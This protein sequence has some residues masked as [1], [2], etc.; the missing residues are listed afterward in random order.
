MAAAVQTLLRFFIAFALLLA[1]VLSQGALALSVDPA[2]HQLDR[3]EQAAPAAH[4]SA[5][6]QAEVSDDG[7]CDQHASCGG[8]C[9]AACA[10]CGMAAMGVAADG[11]ARRSVQAAARQHLHDI[12]VISSLSRP[13]KAG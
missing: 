8:N 13:P 10:H 12:L 2:Q 3:S 6:D 11:A 1:P 4:H 5:H 7:T 9:C